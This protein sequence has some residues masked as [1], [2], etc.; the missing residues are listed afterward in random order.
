MGFQWALKSKNINIYHHLLYFSGETE[1][2]E[3]PGQ[4]L[5][6]LRK[7]SIPSNTWVSCE[8]VGMV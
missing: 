1:E 2:N 5:R 6:T 8:E 3:A 7:G 4:A